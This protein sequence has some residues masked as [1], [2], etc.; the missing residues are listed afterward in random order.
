MKSNILKKI[1]E[2]YVTKDQD[3]FIKYFLQLASQEEKA[4]HTKIAE[5][6]KQ[7]IEKLINSNEQNKE[8]KS[9]KTVNIFKPKE[10]LS[11]LLTVT[12]SEEKLNNI[13]LYPELKEKI[14]RVLKENLRKNELSNWGVKPNRK[15]LLY[16][17]PGC[18][19]TITAKAIAS[20]LKLPLLTVNFAS[21]ISKYLG[22]TASQLQLIFNEMNGKPGVYLFDE[23]DAIG[24]HR[25]DGQEV[26][27]IKRVVTS[28]LQM[29]D[30][31]HS[32]SLIIAA[33]N[34]EKS[35]DYALFRR[36][37][38]ILEF[39]MPTQDDLIELIELRLSI[40][41]LSKKFISNIIKN[42]K[43]KLSFADIS[44]A[45]DNAVKN[46]I[47]EER[48]YLKEQ[49]LRKALEDVEKRFKGNIVE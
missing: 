22:S 10:N 35:L 37:D 16:G 49:D 28:F 2:S 9:N 3:S 31:D 20:E 34:Y 7:S 38:E 15:L 17:P 14:K 23:F 42:E 47:L 11:E 30:N 21:L 29:M 45:C 18:G 33:T 46:M 5:E 36:F 19:K 27:E 32:S 25:N 39:K 4:G 44:R 41:K 1:V 12:F 43:F 8:L 24:K 13:I 26:G 48:D 6:L 40:F